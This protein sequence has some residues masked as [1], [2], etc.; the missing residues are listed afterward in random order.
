MLCYVVDYLLTINQ[1]HL[2]PPFVSG[3]QCLFW[4]GRESWNWGGKERRMEKGRE[5]QD[6]SADRSREGGGVTFTVILAESQ[7]SSV[8][9]NNMAW[10]WWAEMCL[11]K[12]VCVF[13]FDCCTTHGSLCGRLY[14]NLLQMSGSTTL[15]QFLSNR[16]SRLTQRATNWP[17]T[18]NM[19]QST[20]A[21]W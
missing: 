11:S 19:T 8:R 13:A 2:C 21:V 3:L 14:L 9:Q 15:C 16:Q 10:V 20:M 5:S 17:G 1:R 7:V 6:R 18:Y 12:C 4:N